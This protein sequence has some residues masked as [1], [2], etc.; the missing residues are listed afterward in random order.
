MN[1]G[2]GDEKKIINAPVGRNW[3]VGVK[4]IYYVLSPSVD[5]EPYSLFFY[6]AATGSLSRPVPLHGSVRTLPINVV[7]VSPDEHWIVW[8]QRDLLDYDVMLV[9]NFR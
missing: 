3:A 1:V 8:A 5:G 6:E 4:G 2:G 7:T 9:E